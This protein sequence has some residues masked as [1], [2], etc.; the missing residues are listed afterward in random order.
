MQRECDKY[1][2]RTYIIHT[3]VC[4]I[5]HRRKPATYYKHLQVWRS[6]TPPFRA[7]WKIQLTC[8]RTRYLEYISINKKTV[9]DR[10]IFLNIVW[11]IYRPIPNPH[12]Y[13]LFLMNVFFK[14]NDFPAPEALV[15]GTQAAQKRFSNKN[16]AVSRKQSGVLWT[17]AMSHV[18]IIIIMEHLK[19]SIA[20]T[21]WTFMYKWKLNNSAWRCF[22]RSIELLFTLQG[23]SA[24]FQKNVSVLTKLKDVMHK[25]D[26]QDV[27]TY[28]HWNFH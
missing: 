22:F 16:Y 13:P 19:E 9:P 12:G 26:H 6:T 17:L 20:I 24:F 8:F 7:S 14:N 2:L 5:T 10:L 23:L 18:Y 21:R 15:I 1:E 3:T 27:L 4:H 11:T 25:A 28:P